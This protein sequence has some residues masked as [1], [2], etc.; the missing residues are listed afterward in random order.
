M[1]PIQSRYV[2]RLPPDKFLPDVYFRTAEIGY[3]LGEDHWGKS[4]MSTVVPAFVLWAWDTFGILLR[5]NS[6]TYGENIASVSVLKKAGFEFEGR[7]PNGAY[8]NG[9]C[10]DLLMYGAL[11]PT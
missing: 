3:W 9:T 5:I 2:V 10:H 6:E 8:K 11:R 7:R 4:V 1:R